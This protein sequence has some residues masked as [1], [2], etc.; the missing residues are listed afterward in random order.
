RLTPELELVGQRGAA[1][2]HHPQV[3]VDL[4]AEAQGSQ[5]VTGGRDARPA[6]PPSSDGLAETPRVY[7]QR[8]QELMLRALHEDE[9]AGE[10]GRPRRVRIRE[11]APPPRLVLEH[12][13]A[14]PPLAV[15][16]G[17]PSRPRRL[18]LAVP[19]WPFALARGAVRGNNSARMRP[20]SSG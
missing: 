5:V 18:A 3:D 17:R 20:L 2:A 4:V 9:I 11:L 1:L 19:P 8:A 15:R 14:P 10:V 13:R 7:S 6:D 16:P 12:A